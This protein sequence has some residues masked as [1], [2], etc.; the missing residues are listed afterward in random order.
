MRFSAWFAAWGALALLGYAE[1]AAA[2][3]SAAPP[4]PVA[5]YGVPVPPPPSYAP[6]PNYAQPPNYAPPPPGYGEGFYRHRL[7]GRCDAFLPTAV[8]PRRLI[9]PLDRPR[10]RGEPCRCPPP[11][12]YGRGPWLQGSV[13]H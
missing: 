6:P 5:G 7:G 3:F 13:I 9:C 4:P 1:Q 12:N 11:A 10:P 8:G 2:Q